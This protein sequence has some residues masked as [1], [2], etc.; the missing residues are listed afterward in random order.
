MRRTRKRRKAPRGKSRL[1]LVGMTAKELGVTVGVT[2]RTVRFYTAERVLPAPEFRGTATRYTREHL[3]C[4]VAIRALQQQRRMSLPAIRHYLQT[5]DRLEV[6]RMA[7]AFFPQLATL[8][9]SSPDTPA[10]TAS[11]A[12]SEPSVADL[13]P[14][15][16]WHRSTILPGLEV[17]LH[18]TASPEVKALAR[19]VIDRLRASQ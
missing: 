19:G 10:V 4:L 12:P 9:A 15:D 3:I 8:L 18:S 7:T 2:A 1:R 14:S 16:T 6:E 5:T 17:H 13:A 11:M